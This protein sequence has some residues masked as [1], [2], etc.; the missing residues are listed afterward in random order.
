[1]FYSIEL[2]RKGGNMAE[3]KNPFS[4][5]NVEQVLQRLIKNFIRE[6]DQNRRS[7]LG[8]GVYWEDPLVGFASGADPLFEEYK[9]IIGS[10][11]FTPREIMENAMKNKR[12]R[13]PGSEFEEVS[14]ISWLLHT[15]E[16]TRR[17]NRMEEQFPSKLWAYTKDFGE[18]CNHA[19]RK[20]ISGY[21]EDSGYSAVA[22]VLSSAF[23]L[24]RD[25]KV[26]WTSNWSERH[27]AYACGLGTFSLNDGF[28]GPKGI[29]L[30]IGSV[31]TTLKLAPSGRKYS[32]YRQNCLFFR[33]QK[34][35]KCI[36][37]CPAG[38]ITEEG[39]DKHKC[40]EYM[41]SDLFK[42]KY[43]EYEL[44][45]IPSACG[46]GTFSL[47]DGFIGPKGIALRIGSVVTTLKLTPSGRKY[48]SY[49]ENC[50]LFRNQKC[51]KCIRRCPAGAITKEGHDKHKCLE[52]MNSD[53]F[54]AKYLEYELQTTPSACGLCQTGVPC[55]FEIPKA[56][57]TL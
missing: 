10:F 12:V 47:N 4:S 27:M 11:H 38:A 51:G 30:R 49:R 36:R 20:Y 13:F 42:A 41:N 40:W 34:C 1:M 56:H 35:G 2:R 53:L 45:T 22:A 44:Q 24:F 14:V 8:R 23:R 29:A 15:P 48:S 43:L 32:S 31:V 37:R 26:G 6:S 39:H 3:R 18:V 54:K 46:L 17:S 9:N 52:Y 28:I 19:L 57:S 50:L 25:D 5:R 16:D 21:L 55:E 7:K 33:N